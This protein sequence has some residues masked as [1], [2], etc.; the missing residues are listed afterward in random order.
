MWGRGVAYVHIWGATRI[1]P[2]FFLLFFNSGQMYCLGF[3]VCGSEGVDLGVGWGAG[4][5]WGGA[6]G[7]KR[8]EIWLY[9]GDKG[10][11]SS[12]YAK[13]ERMPSEP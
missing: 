11:N 3:S 10:S 8:D 2:L 5:V 7:R 9:L 6:A 4:G 12:S 13:K 1:S